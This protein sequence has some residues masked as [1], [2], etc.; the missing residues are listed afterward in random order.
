M[1]VTLSLKYYSEGVKVRVMWR[2]K[3]DGNV[4]IVS[5]WPGFGPGSV[6]VM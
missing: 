3:E 2:W 5:V 4:K 6:Y 1:R